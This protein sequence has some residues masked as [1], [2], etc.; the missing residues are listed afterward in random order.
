MKLSWNEIR[1]R[2]IKFGRDWADASDERAEAQTFWNEL[3]EVFGR[4]RRHVA[5]YENPVKNI[6]G[7]YSFIDLFWP[8]TMIAEHKSRGRSLD[9]AESQAFDYV[10]SL[11]NDGRSEQVPRYIIV[12]DFENI[13]INDTEEDR[14]VAFPVADL[15]K[16]IREFAFI[17]GYKQVVTDPEDPV[18]IQ[19]AERLAKLKDAL[20]DGGY[21]A[22]DLERFMVRILFCLFAE[23]TGLLGEPDSFRLYI[24]NTTKPDGSDLGVHIA[25]W[26]EVLNLPSDKRSKH[27]DEQ[28]AGLRYVN[29]ELFADRLPFANFNR[30]MRDRLLAC[31]NFDWSQ[32]S[33]A[34]FG[35]L[36]QAIMTPKE[37]RQIGAHY[38]SERDI[39]KVIRS[40]FLDDLRERFEKIRNSKSELRKFHAEL[41][42]INILDPACGC[43][44]FLVVS[45]RELRRLE[46]DVLK[47]LYPKSTEEAGLFNLP[48]EMIIDVDQMHGIEIEEW[49]AQIAKVAL[50]LIDHQMNTEASLA[51]GEAFARLPLTHSANIVHA[52]ALRIDWNDVIPAEQ[53]S[54][55]LGNPPFVGAKHLSRS[56]RS[57]MT[58]V[59]ADTKNAGLLD[60]VTAWYLHAADYCQDWPVKI[61]FVSTNSICQ[62]EQAGV[63]WHEMFRRGVSIF[64]AHRTFPWISEAR[65]KAHV[66]CVIVGFTK[67]DP[68]SFS[69]TIHDYD[70]RGEPVGKFLARSITPYLTDGHPRAILNRDSPISSRASIGIGNKPID[71]GY[72]LFDPERLEAFLELEPAA[73]SYFRRWYGSRELLRDVERWI[74]WLGDASPNEIS[75]LS[76]CKALLASVRDYR[77]GATGPYKDPDKLPENGRSV[78]TVKL[79]DTPSRFHVE[80]HPVGE[81]LVIPRH[82]SQVYARVPVAIIDSDRGMVGDACL[83]VNTSDRFTFG[84][85]ISWQHHAWVRAIA[86][87]LKSDIRYSATLVYNNF[88]WPTSATEKQRE[89]VEACAQGV[90]DARAKYP[91]ASL[92]DLYD[93]LSMPKE[94]QRAHAALDRA[95][96]KCY[97]PQPFP[98]ERRRFEYLFQLWEELERPLTASKKKTPR[99]KRRTKRSP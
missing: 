55:V 9:K 67:L 12:S 96:D 37:R 97:R 78:G 82:Y 20:E 41:A 2:A 92:A 48:S 14:A 79:A 85:L 42:R 91:D 93:P 27:L 38:T 33:P 28:L 59:W 98:D 77:L 26:F 39:M 89:A 58:A 63:L 5:A 65:G 49:P 74:L 70:E 16:H 18:N 57:D 25:K 61:G 52:N 32:I 64:T 1:Q 22:H 90:L 54:Y 86:G 47:A 53:C 95:V 35:S 51:F 84:I 56:Q 76:R 31:C 80:N 17:A 40:L 43:G 11:I 99:K 68:S 46:I 75:N 72:L 34:V 36:F 81:F 21:P 13:V 30:D 69:A 19:A 71:G 6:K 83:V 88:P 60:Y 50:W 7:K 44:N 73:R 8:G 24:E 23:D 66:H 29:G 3:F 62:G 87:R 94:L 4:S 15:H 45:Y 10:R